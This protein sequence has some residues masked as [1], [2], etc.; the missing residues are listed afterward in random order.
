[1]LSFDL[2]IPSHGGFHPIIPLIESIARQTIRPARVIILVWKECSVVHLQQLADAIHSIIDPLGSE[3]II[4]HAFYSDHEQGR[5][6]GYD[7]RFLVTQATSPYLCMI[8]EDNVLPPGQL[9]ARIASYQEVVAQLGHEAIVS[10]TIMREGQIQSQGITGFSYWF[11]KYTFGR[12]GNK[13]RHEV[14]MLGANSLF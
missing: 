8:D 12:C 2:L 1:M 9:D 3:L 5:G 7:R 4:Q 10:P 6:V 13:P 14:Q 11:P